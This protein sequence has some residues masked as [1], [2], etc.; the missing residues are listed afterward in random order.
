MHFIYYIN[1]SIVTKVDSTD[2]DY[3]PTAHNVYDYMSWFGD[4]WVRTSDN[5]QDYQLSRIWRDSHA[6]D[7]FL[8]HLTNL[9]PHLKKSHAYSRNLKKI[10]NN[11]LFVIIVRLIVTLFIVFL[12]QN[13]SL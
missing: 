9:L 10:E 11:L 13:H 7:Q 2:F 4:R 6:F 12:L 5:I 3:S 1:R 8:T